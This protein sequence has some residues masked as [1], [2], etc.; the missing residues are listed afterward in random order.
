MSAETPSDAP[1]PAP[2]D[3]TLMAALAG[4]ELAALDSLMLR[5]QQPLQA[6]LRRHLPSHADALDLAQETFVRIYRHRADYRRGARFSTWMFQIALNLARDHARK[7]TRRRTDSLEALAPEIAAGLAAD[8]AS[9]AETARLN[10]E[11]VAVRAALQDLP[12]PLRTALVLAEYQALSHAEIGIIVG[13]TPKA[14]ETRLHRARAKLRL[15]LA[16]WLKN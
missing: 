14:V 9:P 8:G 5:W 1:A 15:A 2:N 7:A 10:E 3:E 6:F 16:R 11:I 13:A 12:E 4:G